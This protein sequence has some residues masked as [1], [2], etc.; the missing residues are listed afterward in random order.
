MK[1]PG[2]TAIALITL[3]I[4]IGANTI[5]FSVVNVL[6]LRPMHVK[7]PD[8]LVG[9]KAR[10][11]YW[12]FPYPAYVAMREDN[13]AFSDMMAYDSNLNF[14]TLVRRDVTRRAY[15]MYVSANYFSFLG[16]AP[17]RGR[18][19][20]P[21]EE[22]YGAE[23]VV[24]LSHSTWQR[25]GADPNIVG[26]Q[27]AINGTLFTI[28]GVAPERFTGTTVIGPDLW[29][30]LGSYGLVG[31]LGRDKPERMSSEVWNYPGV[32]PVGRLKPG[33]TMA[34]AEAQL[35]YLVPRLKENNPRWW[36]RSG[37][38]SLNRLPRLSPGSGGDDRAFLSGAGLFLMSV[39][40]VVLLIA[41]LNL[42][43]MNLV[44]GASRHREIAIR[45]AIGGGRLRIV[46]Q[47]LA[48]SLLLA[49]L[50]GA[51]GLVLAF[52]GTRILNAWVGAMQFPI[53]LT[54]SAR[55][56]IDVRVLVATLGF[57]L[58]ATVLFGLRPA[59]RLSRRDVFADLKESSSG[60]LRSTARARRILPGGFA[61]IGQIALSVV[62]VMGAVLFTRSA[63]NTVRANPHFSLDNKLVVEVDPLAAGYDRARSA[64]V[65][66]VL[67]DHLRSMPRI[68]A[69]G[70]ST[71][72]TFREGG[73]YA[74]LVAEYVPGAESDASKS[75]LAKTPFVYTV[76]V[77][78]FEAMEM[79][80]L[81]GR[82]F[83]RLDST[84]DAAKV[85]IIDEHLARRLRP[86]GNALGC[87]IQYDWPSLSS[88]S[89]PYSVVGIVPNLRRIS[90]DKEDRPHIY[91]P[92]GPGRLPTYIHLHLARTARG[93]EAAL[94][95]MIRAEIRKVDPHLPIVSVTTLADCHRNN[96]VVRLT[97][98]GARL[99][100]T[101]GAM[102]LFL[103]SLGIYGVKGY[104]VASRTHEI[105]VRM[106]V[107]A[108]RRDIL[109]MVLREGAVL[110][111]VGLCIGML[112]ALA[113][114][115][116]VVSVL[117]GVSPVDPM[118]I[119][120]T[121]ALLGTASLLAGYIP[122]RRATKIDPMSALRYE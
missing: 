98:F 116:V 107:G 55:M 110:T 12:D 57:C 92:I 23:P 44:Q 82:Y 101:F 102:A 63:L 53:V 121:L 84:P 18:A 15:A 66:E 3:A 85:V 65:Y 88:S 20:L 80:L 78:Y 62:L 21:Q 52:W 31:H 77:D 74:E 25:Q 41:C 17:A 94:L 115:R 34:A 99:A 106:A 120:V 49:I 72:F 96:P 75:P 112:L 36:K 76:G 37:T 48:E 64:Q 29:L 10:N 73:R 16:V 108:T 79:P 97:G 5:M 6:L 81:R 11:A 67:A 59:L 111:L 1:A 60:V 40:A 61:V 9:C 2:F 93:A 51:F 95:Q 8:Q 54:D 89:L 68:Q 27:V 28:V 43:N 109:V 104:M 91:E 32:V 119:C 117:L 26:T 4:G 105:G 69:V 42:A 83:R 13:P 46:R 45:M 33:L 19:F 14:V 22:R 90:D 122:A 38:L 118:S 58:I 47:L 87:L 35:Q 103:A 86:D 39:S 100:V 24:V 70:L 50:G 56:G 113:A 7:D 114:G 30:P 71:S